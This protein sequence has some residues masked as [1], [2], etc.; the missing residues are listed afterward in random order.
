MIILTALLSIWILSRY[1]PLRGGYVTFPAIFAG[2]YLVWVIPQVHSLEDSPLVPEGGHAALVVM[3]LLCLAAAWAGWSLTKDRRPNPT[4]EAT[5]FDP[6]ALVLPTVLVTVASV[7][8]NALLN[9]MRPEMTDVS[10]WSGPITIVAFFAQIRNVALVLS[11]LLLFQYRTKTTIALALINLATT[12]PVAFVLMRRAEMIEVAIALVGA[13]WFARRKSFSLTL[14]AVAVVGLTVTVYS[15]GAL[16]GAAQ[17]IELTT[18]QQV[19]LFSPDLWSKV[20]VGETLARGVER[21]PDFLNA[22][23]VIEY[24]QRTLDLVWGATLWNGIVQQYVP[25]QIVGHELKDSLMVGSRG[26]IYDTLGNLYSYDYQVGTTS[27]GFGSAFSDFWYF[28]ALW[29]L[30]IAVILK[31]LFLRASEGDPWFQILY[32]SMLPSA[33]L[34]LTHGHERFFIVVPLLAATVLVLR[35]IGNRRARRFATAY[36]PRHAPAS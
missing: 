21:A 7:A 20:D 4:P 9:A 22:V 14:L 6:R 8:I 3:A 24:R 27:T 12:L 10:Q 16:R 11:L 13:Y 23:H 33:L 17:R 30:V 18:G 5:I 15:I 32:L 25:G 28:G 34:S 1:L 31:R 2:L 29:F 19:S 36:G 26:D 35:R